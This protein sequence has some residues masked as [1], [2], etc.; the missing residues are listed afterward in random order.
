M[1]RH[2][3]YIEQILSDPI[4]SGQT[5]PCTRV[6]I[7]AK[8]C[9]EQWKEETREASGEENPDLRGR[10]GS[11]SSKSLHAWLWTKQATTK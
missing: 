5:E 1:L 2:P 4:F 10:S 11:L 6:L 8:D 7:M 3:Y 9:K